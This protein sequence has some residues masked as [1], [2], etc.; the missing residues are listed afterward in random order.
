M[1]PGD[2]A[3]DV[4]ASA[5]PDAYAKWEPLAEQLVDEN[6]DVDDID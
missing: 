1:A 5:F 3:Q 2:A 4:Q 6:Q